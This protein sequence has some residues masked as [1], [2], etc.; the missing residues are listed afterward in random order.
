MANNKKS[1]IRRYWYIA[2]RELYEDEGDL[3]LAA[4][5]QAIYSKELAIKNIYI[6]KGLG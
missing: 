1:K 4:Y 5:D 3:V 6:R 2:L